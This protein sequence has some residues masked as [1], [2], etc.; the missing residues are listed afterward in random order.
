MKG[1]REGLVAALVLGVCLAL[2]S[3]SPAFG[4][5]L[6]GIDYLSPEPESDRVL[7]QTNIVLRPG[8]IVDGASIGNGRLLVTGSRSGVH[9][10]K[11]RLSDDRQTMTFTP[12]DP[13]LPGETV[14]CQIGS[15]IKTDRLGD[16]PPAQFSFTIAGPERDAIP[17]LPRF[18][19]GELD[20]LDEDGAIHIDSIPSPPPPP[21]LPPDFPHITA[22]VFGTPAP[23]RLFLSNFH[24]TSETTNP[25]LMILDNDGT[26][27]FQRKLGSLAQDFKMQPDG[28]LTY[29]DTDA[30]CFY[31]LNARYAVVDSFRTGNGYVTDGH[32]LVI[33]PNGHA[34]LM[35]YDP[36]LVDLNP[37]KSGLGFG[38]AVGLILQELDRDKQ[39]IFQWRSWDHFQITDEI[40]RTTF[41][42]GL[43][44]VHGNSIDADADGNLLISCRSMNELTKISRTTGDILWR[45]GGKNNQFTFVNDPF[46]F[47][48]Q[49][50]AR[51]LPNG[52]IVL[53]DNGNFRLPLFSRA[54]EYAVDQTQKIATL[55][56]QY[57][58]TPD[59]F[60][61]ALGYVQRLPNGNTLIGWGATTPTLT[62]VAPE[63][64]I[65]SQLSFDPGTF[66]YRAFRF[67]WPPVKAAQITFQPSTLRLGSVG[68]YLF[69]VIEP[70][71]AGSFQISDIDLASIRL[72]GV[73]APL[74]AQLITGD[75]NSDGIPDL[76][77]QFARAAVNPLLSLGADLLEVSGSLRTGEV[78]R[79]SAPVRVL[80]PAG[81]RTASGVQVLSA[82]GRL[83]VEIAVGDGLGGARTL[84]I[85]DVQGR[86]VRRWKTGQ[87]GVA[88]WDG[89]RSDGGAAGAGIYFVRGEEKTPGG[90]AKI[91]IVR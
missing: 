5:S 9:A 80:A 24:L 76:T 91:V 62:E 90:A 65:V 8:G 29:Y 86:L 20:V 23:G 33:L 75:G 87:D 63:G 49:H 60:G 89:R 78:F 81:T 35:S 37:I 77:V 31:A 73:V 82:A 59:V 46:F 41:G 55:V 51:W 54:V 79:G 11:L 56:W 19:A 18:P 61:P 15:G 30:K 74:T 4:K 69:A 2:P 34:L 3:P 7:E 39:V 25:Y 17:P 85:Y 72:N 45:M 70:K 32:D 12:S 67:E 10:G 71:A 44:Y 1:T 68:G 83:P 27:F 88:R 66:S 22:S 6:P 13:F 53:F 28:R 38:I 57:R 64:S 50:A 48:H 21:P 43:D 40:V 52:H 58:L 84:A 42:G 14:L 47:T 16:V 26:P 36:E